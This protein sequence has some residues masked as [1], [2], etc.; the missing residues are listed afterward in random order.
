MSGLLPLPLFSTEESEIVQK[1]N[2]NLKYDTTVMGGYVT[3]GTQSGFQNRNK[4]WL[5]SA[6]GMRFSGANRSG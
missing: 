4:N 5:L 3:F 1:H 2:S 6:G